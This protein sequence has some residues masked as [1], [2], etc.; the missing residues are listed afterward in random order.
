MTEFI[1]GVSNQKN[2]EIFAK[3]EGEIRGKVNEFNMDLEVAY[4]KLIGV[5]D[6]YDEQFPKKSTYILRTAL[7]R[8]SHK[9]KT[10]FLKLKD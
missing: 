9:E 2:D 4:K 3:A 5:L 7:L 10:G 8:A 1:I 6:R